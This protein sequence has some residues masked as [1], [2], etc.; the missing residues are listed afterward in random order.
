[1]DCLEAFKEPLGAQGVFSTAPLLSLTHRTHFDLSSFINNNN[2]VH[3]SRCKTVF[4]IFSKSRRCGWN[5]VTSS[6]SL[7][8]VTDQAFASAHR[9]SAPMLHTFITL[10]FFR[11]FGLRPVRSLLAPP[12]RSCSQWERPTAP[13]VKSASCAARLMSHSEAAPPAS[14]QNPSHCL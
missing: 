4:L 5:E 3:A 2:S 7:T 1:M 8:C 14:P 11:S 10:I 12:L 6:L 13:G 9:A